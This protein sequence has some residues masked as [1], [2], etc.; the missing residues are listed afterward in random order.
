MY[1]KIE[2]NLP[3]NGIFCV[4]FMSFFLPK[5]VYKFATTFFLQISFY[6][7]LS[8]VGKMFHQC[9]CEERESKGNQECG[10]FLSRPNDSTRKSL[11]Q[12]WFLFR[13]SLGQGYFLFVKGSLSFLAAPFAKVSPVVLSPNNHTDSPSI[14]E[15]FCF[16]SFPLE[17]PSQGRARLNV[18]A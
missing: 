11:R 15:C 2:K 12:G 14:K 5:G 17:A 9:Y 13:N 7:C 4:N 10:G 8:P 3:L 16:S 1:P 18:K 6:Y